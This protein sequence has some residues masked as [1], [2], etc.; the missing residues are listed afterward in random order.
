MARANFSIPPS[1]SSSSNLVAESA[2]NT[3][4]RAA[5]AFEYA[6]LRNEAHAPLGM[7]VTPSEENLMVWNAVFF[8][9]Q[10]MFVHT[11]AT[12]R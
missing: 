9:H 1:R 5:V 10:G 4:A 2:N 6:A 7:Y 3:V 11:T 8:V 12:L